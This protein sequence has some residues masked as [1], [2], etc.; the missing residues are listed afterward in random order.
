MTTDTART[1]CP[2]GC[3][4]TY[5]SVI[6]PTHCPYCGRCLGC[7]GPAPVYPSPYRPYPTP[8]QPWRTYPG[9]NY[10]IGDYTTDRITV[11]S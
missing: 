2:V 9:P 7:G 5:H 4:F 10:T 3:S 8:Y 6:P 11:W 1:G